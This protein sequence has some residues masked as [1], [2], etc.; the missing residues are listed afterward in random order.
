MFGEH[1]E[2]ANVDVSSG[3]VLNAFLAG[4]CSVLHSTVFPGA[5]GRVAMTT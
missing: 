2:K 3:K 5:R 4:Y 1:E